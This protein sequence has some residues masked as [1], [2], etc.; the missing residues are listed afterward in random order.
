MFLRMRKFSFEILRTE[1][2]DEQPRSCIERDRTC[3]GM[4][5]LPFTHSV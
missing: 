3:N 5:S 2:P 4:F 1:F